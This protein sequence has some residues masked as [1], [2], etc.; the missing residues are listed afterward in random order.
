M[1]DSWFDSRQEEIN[2]LVFNTFILTLELT[3]HYI[4][5]VGG[6]VKLSISETDLSHPSSAIKEIILSVGSSYCHYPQ[7]LTH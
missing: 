2:F 4:Q 5:Q 6:R 3:Q 1:E 7:T